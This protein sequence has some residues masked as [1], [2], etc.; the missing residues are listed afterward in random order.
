[1]DNILLELNQFCKKILTY[2]SINEI[3][4]KNKKG[5]YMR[6]SVKNGK[7]LTIIDALLFKF[8]YLLKS[9]TK[10]KV[11]SSLQKI[12]GIYEQTSYTDK[13][14]NIPVEI[15]KLL[16]EKIYELTNSYVNDISKNKIHIIAFDGTNNN[17]LKMNVCLNMGCFDV[18][19]NLPILFISYGSKNRNKEI[20]KAIEM[21]KS[22]KNDFKKSILVFD[23]F[24]F[25]YG[26]MKFLIDNKIKFIIRARK[27]AKYLDDDLH[28]VNNTKNKKT[29]ALIKPLTRVIKFNE[30]Y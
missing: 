7:G 18:T 30:T 1:M 29:I 26:F 17:D 24:Y 2:K 27:D 20:E 3:I 12:S 13:E 15:Y 11:A 10:D 4:K 14:N 8:T 5:T 22:K 19:N 9:K 23:R 6:N 28:I 25:S 21:I 16:W